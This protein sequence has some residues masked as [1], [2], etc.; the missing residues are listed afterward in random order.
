MKKMRCT[1][2]WILFSTLFFVHPCLADNIGLLIVATG[3]YIDFV[4]ALIASAR[5]NFCTNHEVTYFVF[6]DGAIEGDDIVRIEEKRMGWPYD[7]MMRLAMYH[8]HRAQFETMDYL[9]AID[10][11][12]RIE[13]TV[14]DKILS[15]R[16]ATL[17]PGYFGGRGTYETRRE[18]T[19]CVSGGEG[20]RYFAGGFNGGSQEEFLK[21]VRTITINIA[22]DLSRNIVAIWHDESHINRYFIDNP[23]T[24]ILSPA[25]CY[26]ENAGHYRGRWGKS[27]TR[28]IVA[29]DKAHAQLRQ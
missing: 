28:R 5:K 25:Y 1:Y 26:P 22:T 4:P 24:K 18:S 17:H 14:G 15:D 21:M 9:F 6:T 19:A 13:N 10:A 8:L 16:V 2:F 23:P 27:F 11:D 12:M 7:T 29:L 3:R 20:T